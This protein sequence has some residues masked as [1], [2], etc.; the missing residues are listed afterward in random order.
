MQLANSAQIMVCIKV[1]ERLSLGVKSDPSY[2]LRLDESDPIWLCVVDEWGVCYDISGFEEAYYWCMHCYV[3]LKDDGHHQPLHILL[4][5]FSSPTSHF[6]GSSCPSS[7]ASASHSFERKKDW[8]LQWRM[9]WLF[10]VRQLHL[11]SHLEYHTLILWMWRTKVDVLLA[12]LPR[13]NGLTWSQPAKTGNFSHHGN[14][15]VFCFSHDEWRNLI[16]TRHSNPTV[17]PTHALVRELPN[18]LEKE[19]PFF[20]IKRWKFYPEVAVIA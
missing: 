10:S 8:K 13:M 17:W 6:S 11:K 20:L 14:W 2:S 5:F 1:G 12:A 9:V 16:S 19:F 4:E 15:E 3:L 7:P 18:L